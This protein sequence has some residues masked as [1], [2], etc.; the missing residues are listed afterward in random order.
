MSDTNTSNRTRVIIVGCGI[1]GPVLATFLKDKGY[2]P[3]IYER[4]ERGASAG[5]SLM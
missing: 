4:T 3:V 1:A 5:L 2:E